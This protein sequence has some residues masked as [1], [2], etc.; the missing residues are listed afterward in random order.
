MAIPS[1]YLWS[2][3]QLSNK[4]VSRWELIR[5]LGELGFNGPFKGSGHE[6][7][8]KGKI[9]VKLPNVHRGQD[10]GAELLARILRDSG[11]RRDEWF[12][13]A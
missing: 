13:V 12:S 1:M 4:L 9:R 6:F 3:Y 8:T 11:I 5:R 7:M 10:V 2:R